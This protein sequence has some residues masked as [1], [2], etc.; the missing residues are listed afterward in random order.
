MKRFLDFFSGMTLQGKIAVVIAATCLSWWSILAGGY[1]FADDRVRVFTHTSLDQGV[2]GRFLNDFFY[3]FFSSGI[4]ADLSPISQ[5]FCL[6]AFIACGYLLTRYFGIVRHCEKFWPFLPLLLVVFPLNSMIVIYRYD[7]LGFGFSMLLAVLAFGCALSKKFSLNSL[8]ALLLFMSLCTYQVFLN[9]F[10]MLTC[11]ALAFKIIQ[12]EQWAEIIRQFVRCVLIFLAGC[13]LYLPVSWHASEASRQPFADLPNYPGHSRF[14]TIFNAD[15]FQL[16][17]HNAENYFQAILRF[18]GNNFI[19]CFLAGILILALAS[20]VFC[21]CHAG[22]KICAAILLVCAF[23]AA[24]ALNMAL[25]L[26]VVVPRM[27]VVLGMFAFTLLLFC[28]SLPLWRKIPKIAGISVFLFA[29]YYSL[30]TGALTMMGNAY[31]VQ[32]QFEEGAILEPLYHDFAGL[33]LKNGKIS[34]T[35][36]GT[37]PKVHTFQA[38]LERYRFLDGPT[39]PT[40][41]PSSLLMFFP[42]EHLL[43]PKFWP[44]KDRFPVIIKRLYYEIREVSPNQYFIVLDQTPVPYKPKKFQ[45]PYKLFY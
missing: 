2:Q 23:F 27:C 36:I 37:V 10:V 39:D 7:S 38:L 42:S 35:A 5:V 34:F 29:I 19:I 25:N 22:R 40:F 8:G 13:V 11:F 18:F 43:A 3:G 17:W 6:G 26:S 21:R 12:N 28:L 33:V 20:I 32:L 9:A 1:Y 30:C 45:T 44:D 31:E 15:F 41:L 4:F 16:L 14:E 24:A